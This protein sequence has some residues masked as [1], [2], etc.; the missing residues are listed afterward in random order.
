[1]ARRRQA[2]SYAGVGVA[3]VLLL[4]IGTLLF[5][6]QTDWGRERVRRSAL[7]RLE[8]AT[9]GRIEIGRIEGNLL[10]RV[11]LIDV[12]IVDEQGRPFLRA[13]TIFT[14]FSLAGLLR[15]SILLTD[16]RLV[17]PIVVL[18][19][20]PNEDWNYERIFRIEPDTVRIEPRRPGWGD[21]I[22]LRDAVIVDGRLT[23]RTAWQPPEGLSAEERARTIRK[24]LAG[25]TRELVVEVPG[26]HQNVMEFGELHTHLTRIVVAHPDTAGIPI[27]VARFSGLVQPFEPPPQR[28]RFLSGG[29]R[30]VN[31]SLKF[32]G[33]HTVLQHSRLAARGSYDL[34]SGELLLHMRGGPLAFSD[35]RWLYPPLPE[36]GG[37]SMRLRVERRP[38]ATRIAA[39]QM[40]VA[41][42]AARVQGRLDITTGDTVLVGPT[43]LT[44][45][46]VETG[47][48]QDLLP[49]L[50]FP[51]P[52][53]LTGRLAIQGRPRAL[54]LDGDVR[55]DDVAGGSSRIT[56]AGE[57]GIE[58]ALRFRN[59]RLRFQPLQARLARAV[60]PDAPVRG[61]IEG[62][63]NLT[64]RPDGLLQLDSDLSVRDPQTGLSRVRATGG[65]D[66]SD[67]L[68]LR[69]L[70]VRLDPLQ[71]D[72]VR[73]NL[74]DL[75]ANATLRGQVRLDGVPRR[76]LAV[77]GDVVLNDPRS[78]ESRFGATGGVVMQPELR[79]DDLLL[80]LHSVRL[81]LLREYATELPA[82]IVTG[83]VRVDG[84][85]S[86]MLQV[87][88][89]L[90][91]HDASTGTSEVGVRGGIA[92]AEPVRFSDLQLRLEPLRMRL[93]QA[94]APDLPI[95]GTLTGTATL[96]GS[97]A[98]QIA[99]R[100]DLVHVEAGERSHVVGTAVVAT[101][102]GGRMRVD[103]SLQP[104]S[105]LTAGRFVPAAGLHGSVRGELRA[106][107]NLDDV[108]IDTDLRVAGGGAIR[109]LGTLDLAREQI[110][111]SLDTRMS[112]F[113]LA[114]VTWRA[115]AVTDLTGALSA[116]G[117]GL[118]PAT[119]NARIAADLVASE[120]DDLGADR[121]RLRVGIER[122]L[123]Q[124]DSSVIRLGTAEAILDGS[125]GLVATR[126]GQLAYRL[127]VDSLHAFAPWLP[128]ADTAVTP[129][130]LIALSDEPVNDV[131]ADGPLPIGEPI[132][133]ADMRAAA[134]TAAARRAAARR[135]A[136]D[137]VAAPAG[138]VAADAVL[139][140]D[141]AL[142]AAAAGAPP[143]PRD[144]LAGSLRA[145]GTLS[146]NIE[147]FDVAGRA[148]V[149]DFVYA[150]TAV[151]RGRADYVL[152]G[153][154]TATPDVTVKAEAGDV[155]AAGLAFYSVS[156]DGQYRGARFGE[157]RVTIA[158]VQDDA[159]DYRLD[160]RFMLSLERSE[161]RLAEAV[162]RFDTI[163]WQTTRPGMIGWSGSGIDVD[164]IELV[165]NADGRIYV[166]GRLPVDGAADLRV[167]VDNVEIAQLAAL[168][169]NETDVS[170]RLDLQ[171][172]V[173]GSQLS[174]IIEGTATITEAVVDGGAA[175]DV[176]VVFSY[177]GRELTAEAEMV[178]DGR[179]LADATARL[180][181]DLAL[182]T[183][184]PRRL[185]PGPI[186][187]DIRA[188]SLPLEAIP[189]FTEHV[190]D[191]RGRVSGAAFIR[192][193][194]DAPALDGA[195]NL[196]LGSVRIVPLGV[197]FEEVAGTL[198]LEGRVIAVDSLVATSKGPLRITGE[199]DV[200]T[201]T[202]P[203]LDLELEAR[204]ARIMDTDDL[205]LQVDADLTI[206][207]P[208]T[209]VQVRGESHARSGMLRIPRLS[210]I[211]R[212]DIVDLDDSRTFQAVDTTFITERERLRQR[213]AILRN[214]DVD[215]GLTVDRDFWLRSMETNVEI[216]TPPEV[217]PLRIRQ[218]AADGALR[219][220]GTINT[221]RGEYEFM[222]RRFN[223]TRGAV[224]FTGEAELDPF[225]QV[226]AQHE[227]RLPG[228]E[229]FDMRV[230][231]NGRL[232]DFAITLESTAQPPIS[233][234]DLLSYL[235]FGR[236]A[237]SL[238]YHQGGGLS[239]QG[240][241]PGE[242]VGNVAAMA[243][244]QLAAVALESVV[245]QLEADASRELGLDVFRITP[246]DLPAEVFTGGY[247]DVLRGT[248]IE[249]GRYI[250]PRLFM[251]GQL[252]AG[253][254]RPGIR[255]EYWSPWGL[256]WQATWHTR[257]VP[258]RPT[259]TEQE[260]RHRGVLG[261]FV[262]REWRF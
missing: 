136:A 192:G 135:A 213:P 201:L 59:L 14:R 190:E 189:G 243:T 202:E 151:G 246:A 45:A 156:V 257:F 177:A 83:A 105:L 77:D 49:A 69:N 234:T 9:D 30:L 68:R 170:G 112:G 260:V 96:D 259:L 144:S 169:Q 205:R 197:R 20:P 239:G 208:L 138:V 74:P 146:G 180:P 207:G 38:L 248:E 193:T 79:F 55:F 117:R 235:A 163:T 88:G 29:F 174:P 176:Q 184:V 64:G 114:A 143:V 118:E 247:A 42:G 19:R 228:R 60:I 130:H 93:V 12:T 5:I 131:T 244:Q 231:I 120:I 179:V 67:E 134:D 215:I 2:L 233:Q 204:N 127:R 227:V 245:N 62:Y 161:L 126:H 4:G 199:I 94:F 102:P 252:R 28:V 26:G 24:A 115:P 108:R 240:G 261:A 109:A 262:F 44:F 250:S 104:L 82:G 46:R 165:S 70:L 123:A 61:T 80:R 103:A 81:A 51:R 238:L 1:M 72:L 25:E 73:E 78:G 186:E 133:G 172:Q 142:I 210:D 8:R 216:Y 226:A 87:A 198:S 121:V 119:M 242:L 141:S 57:L 35:M 27:E 100:G 16:L 162:L 145:E 253:M 237:S 33:I 183:G 90:A 152:A 86:G 175:P 52:G 185:L 101:G 241:G 111:Y 159:T 65:I 129:P 258:N 209:A 15:R 91:H 249:A 75:P 34:K 157:G 71:L 113:N 251:A 191:A 7:D 155:V 53:E 182:T 230:V 36:R 171:A 206:A 137:T 150:G 85:P 149:R 63:A 128:G 167:E 99:V 187:V 203:V 132:T 178:H 214:L 107:G 164:N 116:H 50:K 47:M 56:A 48:V 58:P 153:L 92:L 232:S 222:S 218:N 168:L 194:F 89:D 154:S 200:S 188:D 229:A 17:R 106:S 140:A 13:D 147:A 139:G 39:D 98:G 110:G 23:I 18:D 217:G 66:Q 10:R 21:R 225:I 95:G 43:D 97:P 236:D 41:V 148:E 195:V 125:F 37:G 40:E 6:A 31:D 166:D 224:S 181:L 22:E 84:A 158:A 254:T 196:D 3:V 160:A 76:R 124:I 223:L 220:L 211:G 173:A 32:T 221:D 255:M 122:G 256:Q 212:G 219:L 11:R 54:Q